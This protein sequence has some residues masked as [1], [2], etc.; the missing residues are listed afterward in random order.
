MKYKDKPIGVFDS[1]V[2]GL[3]VLRQLLRL[4]PGER[5]IYLGDTARVPYGNKSAETIK[6]YTR[7]CV[8]FLMER[9]VKLIVAAC[10]TASSFALNEAKA[11]S[12]VP[13]IDVILP[14]AQ[15]A[16]ETTRNGNIGIIGTRATIE[17]GAYPEAIRI[18]QSLRPP[19][20]RS[21]RA[22]STACPLFVPLAEEDWGERPAARLIAEEYLAP[23]R[24]RYIDTLVLGCTHYPLLADLIADLLPSVSLVDC[25]EY[26]AESAHTALDQRDGLRNGTEA[27]EIQI[28]TTDISLSFRAV[29]DRFLGFSTPEP[30]NVAVDHHRGIRLPDDF[31]PEY[32]V[33]DQYSGGGHGR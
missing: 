12:D 30:I 18:F 31:T 13:V 15:A 16:L 23:F 5:F 10:N 27:A 4:L 6:H 7:Q 21:V 19:A 25:G 29:A 17:S 24:E 2:G 20:T 32:Y 22:Y 14:A 33:L 26:A 3:T 28:F 11:L 8:E 9:D 1:G